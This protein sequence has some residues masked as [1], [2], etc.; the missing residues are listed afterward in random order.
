MNL[1]VN[2]YL[3]GV[4]LVLVILAS[5]KAQTSI[6][7]VASED[8]YIY[9]YVPD[10]NYG[11]GTEAELVSYPFGPNNSK[12]FVLK[13]DL[14]TIP[15]GAVITNAK[16]ELTV[17]NYF[18]AASTIGAYTVSVPWSETSVN[19]SDVAGHI[20]STPTSTKTLVFPTNSLGYVAQW[21]VNADVQA[22]VDGTLTN[23]GWLFMDVAE[24]T[25]SY[26]FWNFASNN[27]SIVANRPRLVV[28]YTVTS[29]PLSV[30]SQHSLISCTGASDGAASVQVTG[31][32]G[33]YNY[34]W[35]PAPAN[36]QGT[37][38]V[39]GLGT[40]AWQVVI[41]DQN[42]PLQTETV[43]FVIVE[44]SPIVIS[45][46]ST[47]D[48]ACSSCPSGSVTVNAVGGTGALFYSVD[49]G[50][51]FIGNSTISNL[52]PGQYDV[53]VKDINGCTSGVSTVFLGNQPLFANGTSVNSPCG[54]NTGS[55]DLTISGGTPPYAVVWSQ[56]QQTEDIS[57]IGEGYYLAK[58]TDAVGTVYNHVHYVAGTSTWNE[59]NNIVI[60][61][62]GQLTKTSTNGWDGYA[63]SG[64]FLS[65]NQDG[66]V[67]MEVPNQNI[68]FRFGLS[69]SNTESQYGHEYLISRYFTVLD[70]SSFGAQRVSDNNAYTN[71]GDIIKVER[72]GTQMTYSLNN[73]V[74]Y[75]E[76][77]NPNEQLY[78]QVKM[79]HQNA[80]INKVSA[81]F[82]SSVKDNEEKQEYLRATLEYP[83]SFEQLQEDKL[84]I[85]YF[86]EYLTGFDSY[87]NFK[88][89]DDH[90]AVVYSSDDEKIVLKKG[91]N[92][93]LIDCINS[94]IGSVGY[95]LLVAENEKGDK[96]YV[97]FRNNNLNCQ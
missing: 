25:N 55:I 42:D 5:L 43:H 78:L 44:P 20:S 58:I 68:S 70:V 57:G 52:V 23:N 17:T 63:H 73:V 80:I 31:G 30:T 19:W 13:F 74:L 37:F 6:S 48:A 51:T 69:T 40:G 66:F 46:I 96:R 11:Y 29:T 1:I 8:S 16:I 21:D 12:R 61:G 35:S 94:K 83:R 18:H 82:C 3:L 64:E 10:N 7:L 92:K 71:N 87:L 77:V 67:E 88:I 34:V 14:S 59:L 90:H 62:G 72:I 93:I 45:T 49:G 75:S 50:T 95:Y 84:P 4:M 86:E 22:M 28:D 85:Y 33:A 39:T 38:T 24:A 27:N 9:Q 60:G 15:A 79:Y 41:T 53:V 2:R 81:S 54:Q 89:Y 26:A 65:A 32:S 76:L 56:G 97:R 47:I 91:T 36:G